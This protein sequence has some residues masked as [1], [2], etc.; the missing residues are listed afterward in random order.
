MPILNSRLTHYRAHLESIL[1]LMF[2]LIRFRDQLDFNLH[3]FPLRSRFQLSPHFGS[4]LLRH[5]F[6]YYHCPTNS[7]LHHQLLIHYHQFQFNPLS[8]FPALRH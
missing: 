6:S 1:L 4:L 5:Y 8:Q 7:D 2:H 3:L